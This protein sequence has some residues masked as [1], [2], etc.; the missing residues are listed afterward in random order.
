MRLLSFTSLFPSSI[1]PN[2]G[3]FVYQRLAHLAKRNGNLVEVVAPLPY[4]PKRLVL[5]GGSE[6]AR[7]PDRERIGHLTVHHPR[8][9]LA[10]KISMPFHG[11]SMYL[12]AMGLARRLHR[13]FRFDLVDGHYVYP[14]GLGAVLVA[15]RLGLPVILTARGTD[16][17]VFPRFLTI[18]PQI[19][20]SLR[21]AAGV[22]TVSEALKAK[23]TGLGIPAE[24]VR[25]IGN[26]V[27]LTRFEP[28]DRATARR[29]L[30]LP[31]GGQ[32]LLSVGALLATKGHGLLLSSVQRLALRYPDLR[33]YI[34]GDGPMRGELE[35]TI[36]RLR[37]E[38]RARLIGPV[39]NEQ[40]KYWYS[41]ATVSCL[42]S[43]RE[44]WPNVLLEALGCGTPV[45]STRVGGAAEVIGSDELGVL[46]EPDLDSIIA[47]LSRA[48]ETRWDRRR[49]AQYA[50]QRTWDV[51]ARELEDFLKERLLPPSRD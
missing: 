10:P 36:R 45:V 11:L 33:A 47:G 17:N 7:V 32:V 46:V 15:R 4:V 30:G 35:A 23:V 51:V 5:A 2:H 6:F 50:R 34:V 43:A 18:R 49:L 16:M 41:G 20:W 14:D 12:G 39:G 22:V 24:K 19:R 1:K 3:I 25:T 48:L 26:G 28:L 38:D 42:L 40:L 9:P 13:E 44:G 27:D 31:E 29:H 8:Y 37:L 21:Q